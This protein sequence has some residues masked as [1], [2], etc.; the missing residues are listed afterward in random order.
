MTDGGCV[1]R[2]LVRGRT[3]ADVVHEDE[4]VL[5]FMDLQPVNPGHLLVVCRARCARRLVP[6]PV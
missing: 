5:A 6:S 3:D 2:S 1:F 4:S